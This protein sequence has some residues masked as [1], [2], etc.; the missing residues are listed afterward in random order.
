NQFY[1]LIVVLVIY[2]FGLLLSRFMFGN[3]DIVVYGNE[4]SILSK[5]ELLVRFTKAIALSYLSLTVI[6]NL[7]FMLSS[8]ME[9]S[10]APIVITMVINIVFLIIG[11][12]TF[13][14]FEPIQQVLFTKHMS[15]WT[16]SFE[17]NP[18][19]KEMN[20]SLI[21]LLLYILGFFSIAFYSF[22]KKDIT[23]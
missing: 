20:K 23:Q 3:G 15:V 19:L 8:F 14:F 11:S 4:I 22:T 9:N 18:D 6:S 13:E 10:V 1:L 21:I 2:F 16:Y 12:L 5:G 17:L 7:A